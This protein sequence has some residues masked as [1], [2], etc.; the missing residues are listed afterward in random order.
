VAD[1]CSRCGEEFH[2]HT[3]DDYPAYLVVALV[4]HAVFPIVLSVDA[5]YA[6]PMWAYVVVGFPLVLLTILAAL[7]PVKGGVVA[8][9]WY[10][11]LFGFETAKRRRDA[12]ARADASGDAVGA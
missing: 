6:P 2:H 1:T 11:G 8:L 9:Q 3:A 5:A 12:A 10:L 4:G 7:Q